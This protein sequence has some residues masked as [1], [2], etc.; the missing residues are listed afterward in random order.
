MIRAVLDTNILISAILFKSVPGSLLEMAT[1]GSFRP[2]TSPTL[3]DE[4]DEKLR[5]KFQLPGVEADQV[6]SDLE[7]LCDVVST[8]D[9]LAVIKEDPDDDRVLERAIAGRADYIVS[10]DRHLLNLSNFHGIPILT[11]RQ[12]IDK[13]SLNA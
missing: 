2:V 3:L 9:H 6:R 12:F 10:G 13:L 1:A 7:E 11:V 5:G 8:I 4:L